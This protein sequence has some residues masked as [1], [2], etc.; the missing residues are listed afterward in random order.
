MRPPSM[1][2]VDILRPATSAG[3]VRIRGVRS[4]T[5]TIA[6]RVVGSSMARSATGYTP[7]SF[8]SPTKQPTPQAEGGR[9]YA[10]RASTPPP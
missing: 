8:C 6:E 7:R 10:A 2:S 3:V 4:P 1:T 5:A 9:G